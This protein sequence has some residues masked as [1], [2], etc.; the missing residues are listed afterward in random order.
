MNKKLPPITEPFNKADKHN[1]CA[2]T[3]HVLVDHL[4][5]GRDANFAK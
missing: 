5:L 2:N 3:K 4:P 1:L